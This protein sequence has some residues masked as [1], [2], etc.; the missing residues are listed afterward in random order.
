MQ[1]LFILYNL[2]P[3]MLE[4]N[5]HYPLVIVKEREREKRRE[6]E[7]EKEREQERERE[8]K[9]IINTLALLSS[10]RQTVSEP[11][12]THT[13]VSTNYTLTLPLFALDRTH[14]DSFNWQS[15]LPDTPS[16]LIRLV[17]NYC[18]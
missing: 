8:S 17:I 18:N 12:K 15:L 11:R 3:L 9:L 6:K 4:D 10:L 13:T 14:P 2:N 7:R 1:C 5:Q 16:A